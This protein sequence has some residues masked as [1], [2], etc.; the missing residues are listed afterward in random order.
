MIIGSMW[1]ATDMS[2][3]KTRKSHPAWE[4]VDHWSIMKRRMESRFWNGTVPHALPALAE[5]SLRPNEGLWSG[6][7]QQEGQEACKGLP[8][9]HSVREISAH[10]FYFSFFPLRK[11]LTGQR[12][13]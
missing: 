10:K 3:P 13:A 1:A 11:R 5:M 6:P 7:M 2:S 8:D 4:D 12:R 9:V